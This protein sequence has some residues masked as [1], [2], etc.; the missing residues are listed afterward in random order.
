MNQECYSSVVLRLGPE[1]AELARGGVLILFAEPV[2]EALE[3]VSV[4][5]RPSQPLSGGLAPGDVLQI[6][7]SRLAIRAVGDLAAE[8]LRSLGHIVLYAERTETPLLAGAVKVTGELTPP[9]Q[10]D[11]IQ[12]LHVGMGGADEGAGSHDRGRR[13]VA[14]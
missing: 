10:G 4:V 6:G 13:D 11:L 12:I 5:H 2:P 1:V 9:R 7:P 14:V 8:N 3:S